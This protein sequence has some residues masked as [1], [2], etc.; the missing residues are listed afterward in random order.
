MQG[1]KLTQRWTPK[2]AN[3]SVRE[4]AVSKGTCK[5]VAEKVGR[6]QGHTW[7]TDLNIKQFWEISIWFGN[8]EIFVNLQEQFWWRVEDRNQISVWKVKSLWEN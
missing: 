7:K 3:I 8:I 2:T 1:E 5:G 6:K 4:D